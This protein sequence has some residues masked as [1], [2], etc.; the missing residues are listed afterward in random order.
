M[1]ENLMLRRRLLIALMAVAPSVWAQQPEPTESPAITLEE[2]RALRGR[3]EQIKVEAE[4]RYAADQAACYKKFLV[5]DCLASAKQSYTQ[6]ML[7]A[8]EL[9]KTGRN[10]EREAHREDV[11]AKEAAR[12]AQ[13][14]RHEAEQQ[15]Q[16]ER[17]REEE[18]KKT[19]ERERK[20]ADK[21]KQA[22]EGRRKSE[23]KQAARQAKQEKRA[24]DDAR[25]AARKAGQPGS[26][27]ADR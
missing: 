20:L 25:R 8:R 21:E 5:N 13:A 24:Q 23:A 12:A 6:S 16:G 19:A 17:Y 1:R 26:A 2:A 11:E 18:A 9:D 7:K 15:A 10:V 22:A 27:A 14:A 4:Q 3:A